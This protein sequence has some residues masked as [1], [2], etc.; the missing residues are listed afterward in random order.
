MG[1]AFFLSKQKKAQ[2]VGKQDG[3]R[4]QP[5]GE[6]FASPP[7]AVAVAA[8]SDATPQFHSTRAAA[9][10]A[11]ELSRPTAA[12]QAAERS[13]ASSSLLFSPL[14]LMQLADVYEYE[15]KLQPVLSLGSV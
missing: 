12:A 8:Q 2:R 10:A 13:V 6:V 4:R 11:G 7:D 9:A 14:L 1:Y 3:P 15:L 5:S